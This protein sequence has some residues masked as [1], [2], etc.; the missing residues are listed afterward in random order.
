ME[1]S[2]RLLCEATVNTPSNS[3]SPISIESTLTFV[4]AIGDI[5]KYGPACVEP[6]K[7]RAWPF[8]EPDFERALSLS[9]IMELPGV[10]RLESGI[11]IL[12]VDTGV[13]FSDSYLAKNNKQTALAFPLRYFHALDRGADPDPGRDLNQDGV[14]GNGGWV[15]VNLSGLGS[16]SAETSVEDHRNRSH[17][18]QVTTLAL[19]GRDL[20]RLRRISYLPIRLGE[21]SLVPLYTQNPI[22][23]RGLIESVMKYAS[24]S[25]NKFKVINLS[26]EANAPINGLQDHLKS[27][28]WGRV[29]VVAAGNDGKQLVDTTS[30]PQTPTTIGAWPALLGGA[31]TAPDDSEGVIITVGAH[32]GAGAIVDFSN[33]GQKVDILAPGCMLPSYEIE[34]D[35]TDKAIGFKPTYASGTS[36]SAPIVSFVAGLLMNDSQFADLPGRVKERIQIASDY[37]YDL[38]EKTI[39]SGILNVAKVLGFKYDDFELDDGNNGRRLTYGL[40]SSKSRQ[41]TIVCN[42]EALPFG[43][44]RKI[45]RSPNG[46]PLLIFFS[47]DNKP[48][49]LKREFCPPAILDNLEYEFDDIET[50]KPV[51]VK[52]NDVWDYI[53][54]P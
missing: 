26:L 25:G 10:D 18:L 44:I 15:G 46:N 13:D 28:G 31:A 47:D 51:V 8:S 5:Q 1:V 17:G 20:E 34:T 54:R 36:F 39:S 50:G 43:N 52:A 12:I 3:N 4:T 19:G 41:L 27:K 21:A 53:A 33:W 24:A 30:V 42:G 38:R 2:G 22:L 9:G 29:F 37:N 6:A 48:A 16:T 35:Q 32:D 49:S 45:A 7:Y 11:P 40:L 23:D 14:K